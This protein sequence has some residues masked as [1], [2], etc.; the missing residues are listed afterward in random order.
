MA[1]LAIFL[2]GRTMASDNNRRAGDDPS[3]SFGVR[4]LQLRQVAMHQVE[5]AQ[6]L[7]I[8]PGPKK[9]SYNEHG[10]DPY[11]STGSFDLTKGW[12][13]VRKR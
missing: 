6:P 3:F 13:G 12:L 5:A 1:A 11:N 8:D 2:R 9:A 10:S 4:E 7:A